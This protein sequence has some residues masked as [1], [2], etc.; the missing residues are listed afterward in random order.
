MPNLRLILGD[1]LSREIS[2]LQDTCPGEDIILMLEV[3]QPTSRVRYHQQKLVLVFS[4][5]RH[6]AQELG[7]AGFRVDYVK[8]DQEHNSGSFFQELQN[9][10]QRHVVDQV[11]V[12]ESSNW[13]LWQQMQS[14]QEKLGIPMEI[15][16]DTRFFCSREEFA[17]W[18]KDRKE[19][20]MEYFYRMLRRKTGW[21]MEGDQP[22]GGQW[23]FDRENR[24]AIPK[25]V[26]I[27]NWKRFE[28]DPITREVMELVRVRFSDHFGELNSFGW[29]VTRREALIALEDFLQYSLPS[30]GDYQDA[31]KQGEDSLFHSTLSPYFNLGLLSPREVCEAALQAYQNGKAGLAAVEGFIRQILGWRE[32]MRGV[33]WMKMPEYRNSNYFQATQPLPDFYWN[34]ETELQCLLE[35]IVATRRNAYAHHI[36]RLMLTGNFALL[37]GIYPAEVEDWYLSVYA[38]AYEWVEMPNTLGMGLYADGGMVASKPYAASGAYINRMSDY[39]QNCVYDPDIKLGERA[40]PFNYLYWN[41][42]MENEERLKSNP[43]MAMPYRTLARMPEEHR[44]QIRNQ[45]QF[46]RSKFKIRDNK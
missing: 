41:F 12:T 8:L 35:A 2:S 26:A 38:D 30:F 43:R 22:M 31:M 37:S 16:E 19:L 45:S 42:M 36:Q 46:F 14:W 29:A 9:A 3:Y 34:G 39:C 24:K 33:Y 4:A 27:P 17:T 25:G 1:Q 11:V 40:C 15:R 28:P 21:L 7:D 10:I 32:F 5:I 23:N 18:A 13:K 44:D 20:R 6:F